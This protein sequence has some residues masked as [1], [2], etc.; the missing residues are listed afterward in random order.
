MIP[1]S[2]LSPLKEILKY[3][4]IT[5]F[6]TIDYSNIRMHIQIILPSNDDN[7]TNRIN[8]EMFYFNFTNNTDNVAKIQNILKYLE[9]L[10]KEWDIIISRPP[11]IPTPTYNITNFHKCL[12]ELILEAQCHISW[13]PLQYTPLYTVLESLCSIATTALKRIE[14]QDNEPLRILLT[15]DAVIKR[16]TILSTSISII[17]EIGYT[18]SSDND[19]VYIFYPTYGDTLRIQRILSLS[20][21]IK[22]QITPNSD[23]I[24]AVNFWKNLIDINPNFRNIHIFDG[25]DKHLIKTQQVCT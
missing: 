20:Q 1:L 10:I 6:D 8:N 11:D 7:T 25:N 23:V 21:R 13:D 24:Y 5:D 22:K 4:C 2:L 17:K 3:I 16:L 14:Q 18:I 19:N 15:K 9:Y 12:K